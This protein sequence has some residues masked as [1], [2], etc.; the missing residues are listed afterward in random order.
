[1]SQ[2][3]R[4]KVIVVLLAFAS[5]TVLGLAPVSAEIGSADEFDDSDV[6]DTESYQQMLEL[7][8]E[9]NEYYE[10][11]QIEEAAD[12]YSRAY[13]AHPQPILLKNE[14]IARYLLE[15]C[16][17]AV[18]LGKRFVETDEVSV[19]DEEDVEAVFG[20]C[21]LDLAEAAIEAGSW[22]DAEDWLDFGEPHWFE[23]QLRDDGA[24]LRAKL[25]ENIE[26]SDEQV[27]EIDDPGLASRDIAGWATTGAGVATLIGAGVW[28][29]SW[30][31]RNRELDELRQ[32]YQDGAEGITQ[33][34]VNAEQQ[35]L[36]DA[37]GL[38][39]WGVPTTYALGALSTAA[40]ITLLLWQPGDGGD[41]PNARIEPVVG[42]E[43]VGAVFT[44][45]F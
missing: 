42:G 40:G 17:E 10:T 7:S 27:D 34:Q 43:E 3:C 4:P 31:R 1:M 15:E 24:E 13:S 44:L 9:G 12:A 25:D 20:E 39:S 5:T 26:G 28:H 35:E 21:S 37:F 19:T 30:E 8:A 41:E 29:M 33:E 2:L 6:D 11:G 18:D 45:S 16:D 23:S 38:V 32:D 36:D 14:M 22:T